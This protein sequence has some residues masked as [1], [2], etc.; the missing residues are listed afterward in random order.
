M[1]KRKKLL[2]FS[3]ITLYGVFLLFSLF[4]GNALSDHIATFTIG[5]CLT[6]VVI[7]IFDAII[8]QKESLLAEENG[9][10]QSIM[11]LGGGLL[12]AGYIYFN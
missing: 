4:K 2:S 7:L 8:Y 3:F 10:V 1:K 9:L 5:L 6:F 12:V 11:V